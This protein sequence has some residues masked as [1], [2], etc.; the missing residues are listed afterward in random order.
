MVHRQATTA[1]ARERLDDIKHYCTVQTRDD[2]IAL[3]RSSRNTPAPFGSGR[4]DSIA[5]KTLLEAEKRVFAKFPEIKGRASRLRDG[6]IGRFGWKGQTASLRDFVL[7]A[8]SNELGLEVP[9]H[10]QVTL[11][12]AGLRAIEAEI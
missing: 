2:L 9:G 4:I 5:E 1:A 12:R 7:A 11:D 6:R 3:E 10:H 8:C